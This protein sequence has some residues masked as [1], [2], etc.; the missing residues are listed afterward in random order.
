MWRTGE[1][2]NLLWKKIIR[3]DVRKVQGVI[4]RSQKH[5]LCVTAGVK[6]NIEVKIKAE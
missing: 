6:N 5:P 4:L 3:L 1:M 2:E